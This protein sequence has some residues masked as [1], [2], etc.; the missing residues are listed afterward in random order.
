[1]WRWSRWGYVPRVEDAEGC[2]AG[3]GTSDDDRGTWMGLGG[4]RHE[5]R[6]WFAPAGCGPGP[7]RSPA[8]MP[9]QVLKSSRGL[10]PP[11]RSLCRR[12]NRVEVGLVGSKCFWL[13]R[14]LVN[15]PIDPG[16]GPDR[17]PRPS[18]FRAG[19]QV[20][21][22]GHAWPGRSRCSSSMTPTLG[23]DHP[24]RRDH[25]NP[26]D[27]SSRLLTARVVEV[28]HSPQSCVPSRQQSSLVEWRSRRVE[29]ITRGG[30]SLER[31]V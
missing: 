4:S 27:R 2:G 19:L 16:P 1:M 29:L 12:F 6:R 22:Q 10:V 24:V 31:L 23:C 13:Q 17:R 7:F 28:G 11:C 5:S 3:Q 30:E 25:G 14:Q 18:L 21:R 20:R 15:R 8:D 26:A 9:W